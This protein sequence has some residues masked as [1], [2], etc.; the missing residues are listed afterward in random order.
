[1]L[2]KKK[3]KR[4]VL[5]KNHFFF[6]K[7]N[8]NWWTNKTFFP[9]KCIKLIS[10]QLFTSFRKKLS[11]QLR[12]RLCYINKSNMLKDKLSTSFSTK[13]LLNI[14]TLFNLRRKWYSY[15]II[16]SKVFLYRPV[17]SPRDGSRLWSWRNWHRF[18]EFLQKI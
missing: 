17:F 2:N 12:S 3:D 11:N 16:I 1:M 7:I 14:Q 15:F 8:I 6:I 5:S 4:R 9:Y 13:L 18:L 10:K